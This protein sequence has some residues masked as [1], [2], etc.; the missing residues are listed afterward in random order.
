M[1]ST[2][3]A[4]AELH[5][6]R[7]HAPGGHFRTPSLLGIYLQTK[8]IKIIISTTTIPPTRLRGSAAA[9]AF[10]VWECPIPGALNSEMTAGVM[11]S[12]AGLGRESGLYV[13]EGLSRVC[14]SHSGLFT[15][16]WGH[17]QGVTAEF[18]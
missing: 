11:S 2:I 6:A 9:P 1:K 3:V 8:I 14:H 17:I 4:L 18:T 5:E 10:G 13:L 15:D 7:A 16:L 12:T